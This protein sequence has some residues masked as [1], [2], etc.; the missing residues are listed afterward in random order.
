MAPRSYHCA[1]C[2]EVVPWNTEREAKTSLPRHFPFCSE[3]CRLVDLG[4][5]IDEDYQI[6]EPLP[7]SQDLESESDA[8]PDLE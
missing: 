8:A 4:H 7:T 2:G 3:K 6:S 5:W 1:Q